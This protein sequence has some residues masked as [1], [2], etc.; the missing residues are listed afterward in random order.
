MPGGS[1]SH[2]DHQTVLGA[3]TTY[4]KRSLNTEPVTFTS[5]T[6]SGTKKWFYCLEGFHSNKKSTK[7]MSSLKNEVDFSPGLLFN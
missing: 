2:R 5:V 1:G 4:S 3:S 6:G 7:E